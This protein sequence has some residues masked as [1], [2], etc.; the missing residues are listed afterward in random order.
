[1]N[2]GSIGRI[3][4]HEIMHGFEKTARYVVAGNGM[5]DWWTNKTADAYDKKVQ[6]VID[7]YEK[8]PFRYR[9]SLIFPILFSYSIS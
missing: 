2:Y 9:V 1:M 7:N 3:I 8:I 6:C 4:G 5:I